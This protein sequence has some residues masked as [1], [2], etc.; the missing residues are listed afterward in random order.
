MR[1]VRSKTAFAAAGALALLLSTSPAGA[2]TASPESIAKAHDFAEGKIKTAQAEDQFEVIDFKGIP[3]ARHLKSGMRCHFLGDA[4]RLEVFNTAEPRGDDVGCSMHFNG[5]TLSFYATRFS[6]PKTLDEAMAKYMG[7]I[8]K[9]HPDA[10]PLTTADHELRLR[11]DP[12]RPPVPEIRT[13]RYEIVFEN[14]TPS[15]SRLSV[16]VV[17]GWVL[18]ERLTGPLDKAD[19][20]DQMGS[21]EMLRNVN[22]M[23]GGDLIP[24]D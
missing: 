9:V 23:H 12:T 24:D 11:P 13:Q 3:T 22:W 5:F 21:R 2:A 4:D 10:K 7:D 16:A 20:G 15:Y 14:G 19:E 8:V 1:T 17:N 6:S 18:E